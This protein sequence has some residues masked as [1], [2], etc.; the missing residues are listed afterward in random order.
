MNIFS[1]LLP[2]AVELIR[3]YIKSTDSKK[4][5]VILDIVKDSVCYLEGKDN[6]SVNSYAKETIQNAKM[7]ED[8]K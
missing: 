4:D 2:L 5:D 8:F 3:S 1:F 7:R 6:N